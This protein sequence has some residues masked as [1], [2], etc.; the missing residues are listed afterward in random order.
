MCSRC[1]AGF[2][3]PA[4]GN[5]FRLFT[6][7]T[8]SDLCSATLLIVDHCAPTLRNISFVSMCDRLPRWDERGTQ[9]FHVIAGPFSFLFAT[10]IKGIRRCFPL[11]RQH[12]PSSLAAAMVHFLTAQKTSILIPV[13]GDNLYGYHLGTVFFVV[14]VYQT[15]MRFSACLSDLDGKGKAWRRYS[16]IDNRSGSKLIQV[17]KN[18]AQLMLI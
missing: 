17:Q 7:T 4:W 11:H 1:N 10:R 6:S 5:A 13:I 15:A 8:C 18:A 2:L 14:G 16:S 3:S 12:R 9:C